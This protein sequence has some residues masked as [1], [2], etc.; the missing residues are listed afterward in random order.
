MTNK[1]DQISEFYKENYNA[2]LH[3]MEVIL[4]SASLQIWHPSPS[5]AMLFTVT[6]GIPPSL[7]MS[8]DDRLNV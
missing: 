3:A 6:K 8:E 7:K 2:W 1:N 4:F 5:I